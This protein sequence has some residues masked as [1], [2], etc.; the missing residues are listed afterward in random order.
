MKNKAFTL[1][2]I[3]V[4]VSILS[5]M[6]GTIF[7]VFNS[8]DQEKALSMETSNIISI[9]ERA[10]N[11]TLFSKDAYQYGVHF[12]STTI[13]LFK[14]G[15]YSA[16]D[17]NNIITE[18]HS[19]VFVSSINL[20]GGGSD[21]IFKKLSGETNQNGSITLGNSID[22]SQISTINISNTGLIND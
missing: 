11:L 20:N 4:V 13:T 5:I 9:L 1:V 18:L 19:K 7:A 17:Q 16:S 3:I 12:S 14:G 15:S 8:F 6:T 10:R 22:N 21:V 2:E